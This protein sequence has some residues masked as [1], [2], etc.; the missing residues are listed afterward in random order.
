MSSLPV[1]TEDFDF[2]S[3]MGMSISINNVMTCAGN[4][5]PW[6]VPCL[7]AGKL[8]FLLYTQNWEKPGSV[9]LMAMQ[10]NSGATRLPAWMS[11]RPLIQTNKGKPTLD[12][13]PAF[14]QHMLGECSLD[15][16]FPGAHTEGRGDLGHPLISSFSA[17]WRGP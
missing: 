12:E 8:P 15:G 17:M 1:G 7:E 3:W 13:E 14:L 10:H 2:P 4:K 16:A 6:E 5:V 11:P 9:W